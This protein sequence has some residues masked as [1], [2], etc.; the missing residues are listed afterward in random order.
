MRKI[1]IIDTVPYQ[2]APY[3]IKYEEVFREKKIEFDIF[4]WD[5]EWTGPLV[6]SGNHYIFRHKCSIGGTQSKLLKLWPM[7]LYRRALLTVLA[8]NN[9]THLVII[10]SLAAIMLLG[11]LLKKYNNRYIMDI[12]DYTYE[13]YDYY[14]AKIDTLI[15]H[16]F[17]TTI[18]SQGFMQFLTVNDKIIPNHN[19]GDLSQG[20]KKATLAANKPNNIG[21]AGYIRYE[22]EN[23]DLM[24]ALKNDPQWSFSYAGIQR[25]G[26]NLADRCLKN[27]I[28]NVSFFGAFRNE[29][30]AKLYET[31]DMINAVY[32]T[33]SLE[34][35]TALPNRLYDGVIFKKP[36]LSTKGTY[37]GEIVDKY[38]LG[39]AV[40]FGTDINKQLNE[41][42]AG[43]EPEVYCK[44]ADSFLKLVMKEESAFKERIRAFCESSL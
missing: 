17:L 8:Q 1:L 9:Y 2:H 23:L 36:V 22:Q 35:T 31:V 44:A 19:V 27:N 33:N 29:E 37:L 11:T 10:N 5:R 42:V 14:R 4:T 12:R 3:I 34:V 43:F 39:L 38:G 30:K 40:A 6:K 26:C 28:S 25:V 21:F 15:E 13:Q 20:N 41:Y 16:S 7:F 24:L 18:S 32:G